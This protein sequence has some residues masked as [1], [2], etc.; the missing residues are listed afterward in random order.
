MNGKEIVQQLAQACDD[1]KGQNIIALDMRN[2]SLVADYFLICHGTNERQVQAIAMALKE[3]M[4]ENGIDIKRMEGLEQARWVL[5]DIDD[6]VCHIFH[7]D[8]RDYYNL[9]R[10]WG[11][12]P[13]LTLSAVQKG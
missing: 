4:A 6:V 7:Q 11:D 9:E 10:L 3:T 8:E 2:V 1:R 5:I 13:R 12:A